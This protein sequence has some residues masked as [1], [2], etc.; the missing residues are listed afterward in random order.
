MPHASIL[1]PKGRNKFQELNELI[2][3]RHERLTGAFG[4]IDGLKLP[5]Q[6][7]SDVD[8]EN[9]TFN[10]WLQ[11]HFVSSVLVFSPKGKLYICDFVV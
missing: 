3:V 6:T 10:C 11:E 5:V 8:I 2:R 9:T 1:W 7:A 4:S